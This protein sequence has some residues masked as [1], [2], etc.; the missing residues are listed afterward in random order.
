MARRVLEALLEVAIIVVTG[1]AFS[2]KGRYARDEIARREAEGEV[3]LVAVDFT[4]LYGSLV[5]G[6]QSSFRDEEVSETGVARW[7]AY[8][9]TIAVAQAI[10]RELSG[11]ILT[12]S[13]SRAVEI[14][15]EADAPIIAIEETIETIATRI[16][17]HVRDLSRR[18]PRATRD[19]TTGRCRKAAVSYLQNEH[20]LVGRA[21]V[22]TRHGNRY[23]VGERKQPY[24]EKAFLRGLTPRGRTVRDELIAAG[25][26]DPT[27]ADILSGLISER[28][29]G[30]L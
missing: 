15:D 27:P 29:I 5:P 7:A 19:R 13:P 18:V 25:H 16:K 2:G 28:R 23:R 26:P 12:P 10:G 14:A 21:S 9:Y 30:A 1:P 20:R 8:L 24:D 4:P 3:G 11:Y 22:A 17:V 6:E